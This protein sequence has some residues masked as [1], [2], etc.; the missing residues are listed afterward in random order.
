MRAAFALAIGLGALLLF[1]VQ[2]VLGKQVLPWFGGVPAVWSTCLV[3]F[4]TLLLAG[5]AYAHGLTRLPVARQVTVHQ[6]LVGAAA[7]ALV[8]RA[9]GWPSPITPDAAWRPDADGS[10]VLQIL[11]L[12]TVAVGLP[13]LLLASTGPLVQ[14]WW[15]AVWPDRSPYRLYALSNLG[16]LAGLVSYPF[17][18]ERLLTVPQQGWLW[19]GLFV[20]YAAAIVAAGR[21]FG[22]HHDADLSLRSDAR[23]LPL[24]PL[25]EQLLWAWL[26]AAAAAL[27]QSTTA[28]L[29]I[30][31][32]AVPLLWMA[33]LAVYLLSFIVA[34]EY[35]RA[36][37]RITWTMLLLVA[38][39]G[40]IAAVQADTDVSPA[41]HMAAGLAVLLTAC[42][43][44]HGELGTRTPAPA[45]L[46]RF[47]LI[48]AAGGAG[49]S[50]ATALL[51]PLLSTWVVEYP[52]SLMAV[53]LGVFAVYASS[54][55]QR[56]STMLPWWSR[57]LAV[58]IVPT[59]VGLGRFAVVEG[60]EQQ[61]EVV[62][63][64]RNF[65]GWVRVRE[66]EA[67]GG[68][69]YRRLLHGNTIHGNQFREPPRRYQPTTYYTE[70]SGVGQAVAWMHDAR[71][72]PLRL[73]VVGLGAGTM[74]AHARTGDLV[75]IYEI[76]PQVVALSEGGDP[77]F[78]YVAE[79]RGRV[80]IVPG[81]ARV[82]LEREEP[83]DYDVLVLDAF[84]SDSV[85]A[86]L[87]TVEAFAL[88]A[89]HLRD[90]QSI[91]AVHVSNRFL[92][93]R[94]IVRTG[95]AAEGFSAVVV[96]HYPASDDEGA[97]STTW[98]LLSRDPAVLDAFGDVSD[99]EDE[100]WVRP[101]TDRWSNLFDVVAD[102]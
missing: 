98:V 77:V 10:P 28:W 89:R 1:Q 23:A 49:G 31:V 51:P 43:F 55:Q 76:D 29:T 3:F 46:T 42:M 56:E 47:Y 58:A 78:T 95:G 8:V 73:G 59:I 74:A 11:T 48:V 26:A 86:H 36:Y 82:S 62:A 35:P 101:W 57:V 19:A 69:T 100:P 94:G 33:P 67:P 14:R 34:F 68:G 66:G 90:A 18:V 61:L 41:W 40:A 50:A 63:A 38:L 72:G 102:D 85:P 80:E 54:Y 45:H 96:S 21:T 12:L 83:Q 65:F 44:C 88:Y 75:R 7:A 13:Y 84:S 71:E 25:R 9:L 30:D 79:S 64:S 91:L 70:G 93:L 5:Y 2:F 99:G 52:L 60:R 4:Q 6:V 87:L 37:H 16:S 22:R 20:I 24:P 39:A 15:A 92:D 81:D 27:L 32:A 53:A 17:L 97:E